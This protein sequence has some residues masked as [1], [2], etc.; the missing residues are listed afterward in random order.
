M[1]IHARQFLESVSCILS[2]IYNVQRDLDFLLNSTFLADVEHIVDC[3]DKT[4]KLRFR[5]SAEPQ[6]IKFGAAR[7]NDPSCNIRFGQLKLP[8]SD[9]AK[10]FEPSVECI[11][12]AVIKQCRMAH[13]PI[14]VCLLGFLGCALCLDLA[15]QHVILVGGFATSDW[16]SNEVHKKLLP[17]GLNIIR[18]QN[19][20]S[21]PA[22]S[23]IH[24]V[25]ICYLISRNNAVS[26]G[27]LS[28]YHDHFVQT[29]VT[30]FTYGIFCGTPFNPADLDHQQRRHMTFVDGSGTRCISNF[31][32][33]IL[34][35][36]S[37]FFSMIRPA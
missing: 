13:N 30:K 4:T 37:L 22:L 1:T 14:S 29:R 10:F 31:F 6:Y 17:H 25:L 26:D 20:V 24:H 35:K 2:Q 5:N 33:V 21:V 8:G 9:V 3:F 7:D 16:L 11:V 18:P 27:A 23:K 28:H 12:N 15:L 32:H 36:V 19:H 34:P